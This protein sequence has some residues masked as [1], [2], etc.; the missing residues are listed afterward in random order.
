MVQGADAISAVGGEV[1]ETL[2]SVHLSSEENTSID[3]GKGEDLDI[4]STGSQEESEEEK[5]K[6]DDDDEDDG[7]GWITPSNIRQL[8]FDAS[9]GKPAAD[10]K[11]GCVTTDFAMQ[12][13]FLNVSRVCF[14][15]CGQK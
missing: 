14:D 2:E 15:C 12:V 4:V 5:E 7:G 10:V 1:S 3:S 6:G 11:V 8:K 13:Q 9:H